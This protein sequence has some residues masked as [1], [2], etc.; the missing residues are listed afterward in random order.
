MASVIV[1]GFVSSV[2]ERDVRRQHI[3]NATLSEL[4]GNHVTYQV[5]FWNDAAYKVQPHIVE[6]GLVT[7]KG[8]ISKVSK[9]KAG[10]QIELEE[11]ELLSY[12]TVQMTKV[13]ENEVED[14]MSLPEEKEGKQNGTDA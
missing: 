6:G 10:L 8:N 9:G 4:D 1:K 5:V 2:I 12:A 11:C 14:V 13:N 7:V 3:L